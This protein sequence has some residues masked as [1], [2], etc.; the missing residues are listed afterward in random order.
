MRLAK[1]LCPLLCLPPLAA[2]ADSGPLGIS[3]VET[4]D[5]RLLHA[6][7]SLNFLVPHTARTFSNALDWQRRIFGW[8]PSER[9]TVWLRDF[10]DYGNAGVSP[11]P[12]P[13]RSASRPSRPLTFA[14]S[15]PTRT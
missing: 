13:A 1:S 2:G 14:C 7:P 8:T 4:V 9:T 3:S 12:T 15:I 11:A 5:L 6:D 10:S